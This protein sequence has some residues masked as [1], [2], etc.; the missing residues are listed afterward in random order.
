MMTEGDK[1]GSRRPRREAEE[2]TRKADIVLHTHATWL[3]TALLAACL[4]ACSLTRQLAACLPVNLAP[5]TFC[6]GHER[7]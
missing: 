2:L 5:A 6:R 3:Q 7:G 4:V 1:T